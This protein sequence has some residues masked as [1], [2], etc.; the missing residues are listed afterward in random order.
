MTNVCKKRIIKLPF[1]VDK[2]NQL[3][4]LLGWGVSHY[5]NLLV[6]ILK[7]FCPRLISHFAINRFI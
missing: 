2:C 7:I 6:E 4:L 5:Q 3:L 1:G